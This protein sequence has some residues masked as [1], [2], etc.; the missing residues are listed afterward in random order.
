MNNDLYN[1]QKQANSLSMSHLDNKL[2]NKNVEIMKKARK[3]SMQK[4]LEI[5]ENTY[6]WDISISW[7]T[8]TE[9][10]TVDESQ[11]RIRISAESDIRDRNGMP[12]FD[13]WT[14]D[15]DNYNFGVIKHLDRWAERRG[16]WFEW[17]NA[18]ELVLYRNHG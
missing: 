16:M 12:L 9:E 8:F 1:A 7:G 6:G 2:T 5:L 15:H 10:D 11:H 4:A 14:N 18:G 13:R 17:Q 3:Y